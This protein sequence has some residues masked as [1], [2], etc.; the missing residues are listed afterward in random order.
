MRKV[1]IIILAA[2]AVVLFIIFV[3]AGIRGH[4]KK[5]AFEKISASIEKEARRK[6]PQVKEGPGRKFKTPVF[7]VKRHVSTIERDQALSS[8]R[9]NNPVKPPQKN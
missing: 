5:S 3:A 4:N 2:L 1:L 6:V 7:D 8:T 9:T